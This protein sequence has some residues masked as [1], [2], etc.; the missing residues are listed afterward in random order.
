MTTAPDATAAPP[1]GEGRRLGTAIV[2]VLVAGGLVAALLF[3][4]PD[5]RDVGRRITHM[6][7]RWLALA[8]ALELLACLGYVLVFRLT[9]PSVAPR[10]GNRLA[11]AQL[12]FG[13]ALPL[14]G[15][16]GLAFG[17][18]ILHR[19]GMAARELAER[20]TVLYLLTSGVN[21][22]VLLVTALALGAGLLSGP[23]ERSLWLAPAA[24]V[25]AVFL[26]IV[27]AGPLARVLARHTGRRRRLAATL[28]SYAS[29]L[30]ESVQLGLQPSWGLLGAVL[31]LAC[32]I[33]ALWAC[34]QGIG[35]GIAWAPIS[36]SYQVGQLATWVP[37]PG[38][39]GAL[40]GGIIGM[41]LV[42][43][44]PAATAAAAVLVYHALMFWIRTLLGGTAFLLLRRETRS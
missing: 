21:A 23:H 37:I 25:G 28:D 11:A 36:L 13:A 10:L 8:V 26:L 2:W 1:R 14:G 19:E 42:Y 9:F 44:A 4:V 34:A 18:W 38:A 7:T 15:V 35:G 40:D 30:R 17:A 20:S 41:L 31:Y 43:D 27:L 5:L 39:V 3:A 16:G 32:D 24:V 22:L 6:D 33:G 29:A 12:A